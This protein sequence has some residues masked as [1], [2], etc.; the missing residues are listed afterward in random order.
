M[1]SPSK[2]TPVSPRT[3][4]PLHGLFK[5]GIWCCNCPARPPAA[6]RQ[7]KNGGK[8]H[9]RW[10]YTCEQLPPKKCGFFLWAD[11]AEPREKAVLLSNSH[12]EDDPRDS[13]TRTP[14]SVRQG[15]PGLLTP[16][17][18]RRVIDIPPRQARTPPKSAKA[19]MMAEDTDEFGWND[20]S[21]DDEELE[22]ALASSQP[23]ES[24]ISQP[25]FNYPELPSS[26]T[27]RTPGMTSPGKR[28]LSAFSFDHITSSS[29]EIPTPHTSFST[30][31]NQPPP[32]SAEVCMTP[33][34]QRNR[35]VLSSDSKPD[36][37]DLARNATAILENHGVVLPNSAQ[38]ELIELLNRYDLKMHGINRGREIL[39]TA[40]KQKD[41]TIAQLKEKNMNLQ[42]QNEMDRSIIEGMKR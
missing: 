5:D 12:S 38:D 37:S 10:F 15:G 7:T 8:N 3:A 6:R 2:R 16:Q 13:F 42:A 39:R 41:T 23:R 14:K 9:G 28:K 36:I 25:S 33:T 30:R 18:G 26:K 24:F 31:S 35:D 11:E 19:R 32:L 40:C 27:P 21:D 17:T 20:D 1:F 34:P 29:S 22:K 4:V